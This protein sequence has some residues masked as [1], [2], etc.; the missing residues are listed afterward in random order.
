MFFQ[1]KLKSNTVHWFMK[2]C[3]GLIL[4]SDNSIIKNKPPDVKIMRN[5]VTSKVAELDEFRN[6]EFRGISDNSVYN[7]KYKK[8]TVFCI[9]GIP[10]TPYA[11]LTLSTPNHL[12]P[13][14]IVSPPGDTVVIIYFYSC[15]CTRTCSCTNN[16]K[17]MNMSSVRVRVSVHCMYEYM[18][19]MFSYIY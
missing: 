14:I 13:Q 10:K 2:K 5:I 15:T 11:S 16:C 19:Y 1:N 6:T 9:S 7:T 18:L 3:I 4:E 12:S 8:H 17:Y